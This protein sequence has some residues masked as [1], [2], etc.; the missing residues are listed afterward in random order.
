MRPSDAPE[1]DEPKGKAATGRSNELG[2]RAGPRFLRPFLVLT[3]LAFAFCAVRAFLE[4]RPLA[5]AVTD[6][7]FRSLV[8]G[9]LAG[10]ATYAWMAASRTD[11]DEEGSRPPSTYLI[12]WIVPGAAFSLGT[13][14]T[15]LLTVS[16]FDQG[17]SELGDPMT[18]VAW[19]LIAAFGGALG[20]AVG[21]FYLIFTTPLEPSTADGTAERGGVHPAEED[22]GA[23]AGA[24]AAAVPDAGGEDE[25]AGPGPGRG[26]IWK[27]VLV[28]VVPGVILVRSWAEESEREEQ[29]EMMERAGSLRVEFGVDQFTA[30]ASPGTP[31]PV[32]ADS[33]ATFVANMR[34]RWYADPLTQ[35]LDSPGSA[36]GPQ[37]EIVFRDGRVESFRV[38]HEAPDRD[39]IAATEAAE[40]LGL[41]PDHPL[42]RR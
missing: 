17:L 27:A 31:V 41:E 24:P 3:G 18:W 10:A 6:G 23:A 35:W 13:T 38:A 5:S 40:R 11:K 33:A 28:A 19:A 8:G 21:T 30:V 25:P 36:M 7:W 12:N 16:R 15:A 42:F 14:V 9:S 4:G 34:S 22:A 20:Y 2:G 39:T 26:W 29:F 32:Y 1:P 37:F